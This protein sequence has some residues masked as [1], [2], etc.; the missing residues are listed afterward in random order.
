M[1][2]TAAAA[3][4]ARR[5][6]E[7]RD[8]KAPR[9]VD[10]PGLA[11]VTAA[12]AALTAA[13][14]RSHAW[15]WASPRTL[16]LLAVGVVCFAAFTAIERRAVNP[17]VDLRLFRNRLYVAITVTGTVAN[18][19]AVVYLFVA[20]LYLQQIRHLS[21]LQAGVILLVPAVATAAAG[22]LA[23]RLA[24]RRK[25]LTVMAAAT[26][27]GGAG[28]LTLAAVAALPAYILVLGVCGGALGL[29]YAFTTVATQAVI[30]PE[31]AGEASGITL[32]AM[33][34][35]G[36][37]GMALVGSTLT[38]QTV[39][40]PGALAFPL[41]IVGAACLAAAVAL[42]YLRRRNGLT[43]GAKS[44]ASLRRRSPEC[45]QIVNSACPAGL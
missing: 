45:R 18:I 11:T 19:A 37:M 30:C 22:S 41:T 7:S 33:I 40:T 3:L 2:L 39:P 21:P 38:G 1:P 4:L 16:G 35:A 29:A 17:L 6:P 26:A 31:R 24:D 23:G 43:T 9:S 8:E 44:P 5:V 32:T 14:D 34:T 27:I 25:P 10:W 42:A 12:V 28:V 15:G 36:G 20:V 13:V